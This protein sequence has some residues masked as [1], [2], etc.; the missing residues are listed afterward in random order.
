M[1]SP[2]LLNDARP[3]LARNKRGDVINNL[4]NA[5]ALGAYVNAIEGL[6]IRLNLLSGRVEV[7]GSRVSDAD[8]SLFRGHLERHGMPT[9]GK[10][11]AADALYSL[12]HRDAYDP[13]EDHLNALPAHDGSARLD[14]W[15]IDYLNAEDTPYT[16][17]V[18]RAFLIAMV[19]RAMEPPCKVDTMLVL[20]GD[21]G[22]GKSKVC[23]ILAGN[24]AWFRDEMPDI[25]DAQKSGQAMQGHWVCE[26]GELAAVRKADVETLKA[27]LAR[28]IDKFRAPYAREPI[29]APR[30]CVF[31]GTTNESEFLSDL[32][33]TGD[34]GPSGWEGRFG[35]TPCRPTGIRF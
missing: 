24:K 26:F 34:T 35:S 1:L 32:T 11:D 20:V 19:A 18:G 8:H 33:A 14:T 15:L 4:T 23:E 31:V 16:R 10:G 13:L 21:Q 9:V 25:R 30:R 28:Q 12:A 5:I 17:A 3:A 2:A 7:K 22:L 6:G 27:F 29:Q